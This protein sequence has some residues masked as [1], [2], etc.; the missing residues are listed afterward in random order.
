V[1]VISPDDLTGP[2]LDEFLRWCDERAQEVVAYRLTHEDSMEI[3]GTCQGAQLDKRTYLPGIVITS[4]CPKCGANYEMD[5]RDRYLSYPVVGKT[6][7]L[8]AFCGDCEHEGKLGKVIL[9]V[10]LEEVPDA[11]PSDGAP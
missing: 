6:I 8:T 1:T 11:P 3:T 4:K 10:T 2:E 9:K 7:E 5:F